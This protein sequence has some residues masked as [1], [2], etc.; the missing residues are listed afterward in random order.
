MSY[1]YRYC[2]THTWQT[3]D[4][5]I[6][7]VT[8]IMLNPSTADAATDDPTIRAC[9]QFAKRW[10]YNHLTIVNLF[11]Y[12]TS[13]PSNLIKAANP[14]GQGNDSY[15]LKATETADQVILAWGNWGNLSN[16]AQTVVDLLAP[17]HHKLYYLVRNR[18]GHPRHPLYIK[19]T[20]QPKPWR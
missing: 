7:Q 16:R 17:Y 8:F 15:L 13:Q 3:L 11:A 4:Q 10:G 2:L 20:T 14:I 18:S 9:S 19:R 1:Q 5:P 12:R 6:R